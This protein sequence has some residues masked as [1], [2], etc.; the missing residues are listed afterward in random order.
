MQQHIFHPFP[1]IRTERLELRALI[2]EDEKE[3]FFFR[4]DPGI[5]E[6]LDMT[7]AKTIE[8]A[9]EFIQKIEKVVRNG[10]S[11]YWAIN[12]INRPGLIGTIC[13]WNIS[14]ENNSAE[15]GYVLHPDFQGK[16][17]INEAVKGVIDY[18]FKTM[19]LD[20]IQADLSPDN[21]KSIRV[22]E[23]NNFKKINTKQESKTV[24]YRLGKSEG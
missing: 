23:K 18:G 15:I 4:S 2:I 6:H 22:L 9:R 3:I 24:Q 13:L 11:I 5:L 21:V 14:V 12:Q 17:F 10:D 20:L 7:P 16:G 8:E 19:K 1:T